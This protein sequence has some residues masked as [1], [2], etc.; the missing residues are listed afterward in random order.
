MSA[1]HRRA[2]RKIA[3]LVRM[4]QQRQ[5]MSR[6]GAFL[7]MLGVVDGQQRFVDTCMVPLGRRLRRMGLEQRARVALHAA[8]TDL[9]EGSDHG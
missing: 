5:R 1:K 2:K 4:D 6:T 9:V 8:G 3:Q 7:R